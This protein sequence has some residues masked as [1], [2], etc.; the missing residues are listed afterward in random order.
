MRYFSLIHTAQWNETSSHCIKWFFCCL[1]TL[2]WTS[3]IVSNGKVVVNENLER[4]Y[5]RLTPWSRVLLE[6]L[7]VRSASQEIPRI[8]WN[9][10][11]HYLVHKSSPPVPILSLMKLIHTFEP[12]FRTTLLILSQSMPRSS[13]WSLTSRLS[14]KNLVRISR[15]LPC[16]LHAPPISSSS[17]WSF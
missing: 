2:N 1:T 8:L 10:K 16:A 12:C 17:I 11:V 4:T 15:L 6:K 5:N 7:R 13:E 3:S 9:P 14:N